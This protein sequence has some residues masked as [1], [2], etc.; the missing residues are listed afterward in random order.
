M[1]HGDNFLSVHGKNIFNK[2]YLYLNSKFDSQMLCTI[3]LFNSLN[4]DLTCMS[5]SEHLLKAFGDPLAVSNCSQAS[6]N[7][8]LDS[9]CELSWQLGATSIFKFLL[10]REPRLWHITV[11]SW[12]RAREETPSKHLY[13]PLQNKCSLPVMMPSF[14]ANDC[15]ISTKMNPNRRTHNNCKGLHVN[16]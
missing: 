2:K 9:K 11:F 6:K 8:W 5:V 13:Q 3:D 14:A 15:I 16:S 12:S 7:T 10:H 4:H 1:K